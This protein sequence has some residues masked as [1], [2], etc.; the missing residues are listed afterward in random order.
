MSGVSTVTFSVFLFFF[1]LVTIL[2]FAAARWRRAKA[3]DNLDEWGLGGRGFGTFIAWFLIGGDLYT[4]YTFVA[5]PALLYAGSAI[6]FFAVP[7]T[8]VVY[9]L[10]FLFLP[11]L[12]SVSHRH[13][14][15]TPADF[16][17][18]RYDSKPLALAV[19]I[20]GIL[21]TMPY[22]A[23]QL[24]G[25]EVVL[26]VMGI[27]TDSDNWFTKDLPLFIAFAVLAAY[28][29]SS[30]L[31]APALIA[32]VKDALIYI[33]ILVAIIY[34]PTQLGGWDNI[35]STT[36]DS[37]DKFNSDNADAIAAGAASPKGAIPAPLLH[38]AYASLALGSALALFMYPH[39]VTAVLSTRE[40]SVIRRNAALLPAYS[41]L[42]GLLALLGFVAI[43]A[44]VQVT[45]PQQAVPQLFENEFPDW[46]AGV[47]FA[48]IV[49][50]ALVPAAI[51]SIAAANLWTRNIYKAFLNRNATHAQEAQQAKVASL[52]VKFGALAFVLFVS[53]TYAL[54]LQLLGGVWILQTFPAI[55]IGLYTRFFHRWA[56]LAGWAAGMLYG[57]LV[58]Y[59]N[60]KV[61]DPGSHF[62]SPLNEFPGTDTLVYIGFTALLLNLVVT[63]A[64][65]FVLRAMNV[66]EGV[67]QTH[68]DDYHAD[69][70]DQGVEEE[71]DPG[72]PV[73]A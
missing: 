21:A 36:M 64:L 42:L 17:Q 51:M 57:T 18:G 65:T 44:G 31:R 67:D 72:A 47:A 45:N 43:A 68:P 16:V 29:Y 8:I 13:S 61:G 30:G 41:F 70:G 4:A 32:F 20:T 49:I 23:L 59:N 7:Y 15:V 50:G 5:V 34:L 63:L 33:V 1:L 58:A 6:G 35:F 10:I 62:G 46:F 52:L 73:H 39:S 40:R 55:V 56:L 48:A 19:A 24:I 12:W 22:I 54:D 69:L 27:G 37:F 66:D 60:P 2:G 71:L 25:I 38:W 28:T 53:T 14:Y 11:R 26:Q 9:P 3:L